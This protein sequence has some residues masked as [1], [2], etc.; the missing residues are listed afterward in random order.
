MDQEADQIWDSLK[1]FFEDNDGSLPEIYL[2]NLGPETVQSIFDLLWNRGRDVSSDG[3]VFHDRRDDRAKPIESAYEVAGLVCKGDAESIHV[4]LGGLACGGAT[5]PDL[6]VGV[7]PDEIILDYR[8]GPE[9]GPLELAALFG[10]LRELSALV[11]RP[12]W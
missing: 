9:W 2:K 5:I 3:A 8:M 6:G 4:L 11:T 12:H 1:E 10:L 7:H